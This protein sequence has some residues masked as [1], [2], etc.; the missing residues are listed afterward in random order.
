VKE[1]FEVFP[2]TAALQWIRVEVPDH[3]VSRAVFDTHF[4]GLS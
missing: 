3:I 1:V 2:E 4:T